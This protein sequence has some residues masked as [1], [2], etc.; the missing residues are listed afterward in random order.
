MTEK[1]EMIEYELKEDL[2]YN[3]TNDSSY[4]VPEK[5][6]FEKIRAFEAGTLLEVKSEMGSYIKVLEVNEVNSKYEES[7]DV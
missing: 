5:K 7:I 4:E 2:L 3:L 6:V 1:S